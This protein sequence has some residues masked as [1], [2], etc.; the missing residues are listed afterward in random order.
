MVRPPRA[1]PR[2]TLAGTRPFRMEVPPLPGRWLPE[3]TVPPLRRNRHSLSTEYRVATRCGT[4]STERQPDDDA[5]EHHQPRLDR[6]GCQVRRGQAKLGE[7]FKNHDGTPG[8]ARGAWCNERTSESLAHRVAPVCLAGAGPMRRVL[9]GDGRPRRE[10]RGEFITRCG[11]LYLAW[12]CRISLY[13]WARGTCALR[14]RAACR[15]QG[16]PLRSGGVGLRSGGEGER[17][18]TSPRR[19]PSPPE[20][21]GA[22]V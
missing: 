20:R 3:Q 17:R 16:A 1:R 21:S 14:H 5:G 18:M 4:S 19:S 7:G 11:C 10:I 6:G 22:L 12:G 13:A 15:P 2:A 8:T 9:A